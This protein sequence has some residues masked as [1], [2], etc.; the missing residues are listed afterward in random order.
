MNSTLRSMIFLL[1]LALNVYVTGLGLM[2]QTMYA[3]NLAELVNMLRFE[4]TSEHSLFALLMVPSLLAIV[5]T[6]SLVWFRPSFLSRRSVVVMAGFS[7]LLSIA[8]LVLLLGPDTVG[9]EASRL[10]AVF[11]FVSWLRV[12]GFTLITGI[13]G[14]AMVNEI[15]RQL[16]AKPFESEFNFRVDSHT[17]AH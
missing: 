8:S 14:Y 7:A 5:F 9:H 15:R 6:L 10:V 16:F 4:S 11:G 12:M 17:K 13:L 2:V 3:N 1:C